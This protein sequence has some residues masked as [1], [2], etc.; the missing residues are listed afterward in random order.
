LEVAFGQ[1][2]SGEFLEKVIAQ[3]FDFARLSAIVEIAWFQICGRH[4]GEV[5]DEPS[6]FVLTIDPE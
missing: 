5:P 3:I 6:S 2:D 4:I 1:S